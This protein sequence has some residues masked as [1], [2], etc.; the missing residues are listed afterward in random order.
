MDTLRLRHLVP[1]PFVILLVCSGCGT[2]DCYPIEEGDEVTLSLVEPYDEDSVTLY[3]PGGIG[4]TRGV[5]S[6]DGFDGLM[7]GA[8]IGLRLEPRVEAPPDCERYEISFTSGAP[9][10]TD[11]R[12]MPFAVVG[13]VVAADGCT[14]E[15]SFG[16]GIDTENTFGPVV[17]GEEPPVIVRRQFETT[18][19]DSCPTFASDTG[20]YLCIDVFVATLEMR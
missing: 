13:T 15:W 19:V 3:R 12:P 2:G 17:P 20:R 7:P 1:V 10:L 4:D 18:D 5:P 16:V 8:N 11:V 14:G 9:T 6:C